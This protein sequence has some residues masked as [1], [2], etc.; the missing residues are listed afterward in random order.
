MVVICFARRVFHQCHTR[1]GW[2]IIDQH[3]AGT[4]QSRAAAE[5][6]ASQPEKVPQN[7]EQRHLTFRLDGIVLA[8][9]QKF[10]GCH[11]PS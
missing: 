6:G 7:P 5:L 3:S 9:D 2:F 11:A 10:K 1:T 4:A 8:V